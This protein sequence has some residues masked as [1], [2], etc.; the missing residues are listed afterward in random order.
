MQ[1]AAPVDQTTLSEGIK[2]IFAMSENISD[3]QKENL[4]WATY[5]LLRNTN[6]IAV[7]YSMNNFY[8]LELEIYKLIVIV[9]SERSQLC[10][11]KHV[12]FSSIKQFWNINC[13]NLQLISIRGALCVRGYWN[14]PGD[15]SKARVLEW[16]EREIEKIGLSDLKDTLYF[17]QR[18]GIGYIFFY[19]M[20]S[21]QEIIFTGVVL[22][23][24]IMVLKGFKMFTSSQ[25]SYSVFKF[26]D[27]G[28]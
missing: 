10:F 1:G 2:Q 16:V 7:V 27:C 22:A 3:I 5:I 6:T 18:A 21:S 13:H 23:N 17:P 15:V 19:S 11:Y 20:S 26:L 4:A 14:T 24:I 28:N 25:V 9:V 12:S 8:L